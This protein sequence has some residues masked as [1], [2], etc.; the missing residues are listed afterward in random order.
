MKIV[1]FCIVIVGP[2]GYKPVWRQSTT[3]KDGFVDRVT[4]ELLK[5]VKMNK[6]SAE[7]GGSR[8]E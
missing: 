1:A 2:S 3:L 6:R 7:V 8:V 5:L 4:P